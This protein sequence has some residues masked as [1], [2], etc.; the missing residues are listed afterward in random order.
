MVLLNPSTGKFVKM[1]RTW[2]IPNRRFD[3]AERLDDLP[4]APGWT[5]T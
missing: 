4:E 5:A 2:N 1:Q 3:V